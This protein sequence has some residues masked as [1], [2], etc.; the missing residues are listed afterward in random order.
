MY[1][2]CEDVLS[3]RRNFEI[4]LLDS[5]CVTCKIY[6]LH[7]VI[8]LQFHSL[9]LSLS[10]S[11]SM[12]WVNPFLTHQLHVSHNR[13]F[14]RWVC[15]I[16][17]EYYGSQGLSASNIFYIFWHRLVK[18]PSSYAILSLRIE[19]HCHFL[20]RMLSFL[21]SICCRISIQ[22]YSSSGSITIGKPMQ[23]V[24]QSIYLFIYFFL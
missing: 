20:T 8:I 5:N 22:I 9:S 2:T 24:N 17:H 16:L 11:N 10:P 23:V 13:A 4:L 7:N 3:Q 15:W 19:Q 12:G 6:L 18:L 1:H 14:F 21:I